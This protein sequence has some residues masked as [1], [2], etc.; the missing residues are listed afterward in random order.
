MFGSNMILDNDTTVDTEYGQFIDLETVDVYVY[1]NKEQNQSNNYEE[2]HEDTQK[3]PNVG[4][5]VYT[6]NVVWWIGVSYLMYIV[7]FR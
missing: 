4:Y 6:I 7:I 5:I 2:H 3:L 1:K